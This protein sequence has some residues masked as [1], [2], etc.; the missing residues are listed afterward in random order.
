VDQPIFQILLVEDETIYSKIILF[1]LSTLQFSEYA[2][3]VNHVSS[4]TE[5]DEI[6][7][8]VLPDI[9]LL[10]LG[11]PESS[12]IETYQTAKK[13]FP[14]SAFIIL[15][16]M[17]D[18]EL[19]GSIVKNGAQDYLVKTDVDSKL[20]RKSIG[21]A[22]DRLHFQDSLAKNTSELTKEL[23]E[24]FTLLRQTIAAQFNERNEDLSTINQLI[25]SMDTLIER[26]SKN[27]LK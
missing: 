2:I 14:E 26:I 1:Q 11:L 23:S 16:G 8:L 25:S 4:L 10:D 5:M 27:E 12:G 9:I 21:Y 20:I 24:T 7:D 15:S 22:L 17:D 19:A 6:K 18:D 3:N 13:Y